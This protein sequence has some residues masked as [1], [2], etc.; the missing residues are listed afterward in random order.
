MH[1]GMPMG[2][3]EHG[4][5]PILAWRVLLA[6]DDNLEELSFVGTDV[7]DV[8]IRLRVADTELEAM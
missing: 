6:S 2:V 5:H 1:L 7:D 8:P 3:W 4:K